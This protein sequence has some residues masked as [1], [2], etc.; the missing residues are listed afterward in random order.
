MKGV[1]GDSLSLRKNYHLYHETN[2]YK[3][4]VNMKEL[5]KDWWTGLKEDTEERYD[6]EF[7][8]MADHPFVGNFFFTMKWLSIIYFWIIIFAAYK[9]GKV[10]DLVDKDQ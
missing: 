8:Y 5:I 4:V 7:D 9:T 2:N 10:W 3:E 1:R 6:A